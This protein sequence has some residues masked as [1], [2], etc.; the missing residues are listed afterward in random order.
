[1]IKI[2]DSSLNRQ[3]ILKEV[4]EPNRFEEI[5][6]ENT[7]TFSA[8]LDEKASTY[9]DE[10]SI[11]EIDGDYFDL[12]YYSKNQNEDGTLTIDV[13]AEHVSYRLNNYSLEYYTKIGTPTEILTE[14]LAGTG[15]SVGTVELTDSVTYSAL[16]EMTKRQLVMDFVKNIGGEID[17]EKFEVSILN[18]RGS[19]S[20]R[21]LTTGK[22]IRIISKV[23]NKRE[24][25][26]S[27][28][29]LVAYTCEP[30]QPT[31]YPFMLGDEVLLIQ[32]DLGIQETL[33]IVRLGY[34]PYNPMTAEIELAN[35]ISG[36][37][38]QMYRITTTTV[39][40][41][42]IYNGCRI[43]PD[44]GFVAERSDGKAKTVMNATEGISIYSDLGSG[45]AKNFFVGLDG[46]IQAKGL[47]ID[48]S[49][50]F[51]GTLSAADGTFSGTISASTITGSII[52]GSTVMGGTDTIIKL[53]NGDSGF[54]TLEF[55]AADYRQAAIWYESTYSI[56]HIE[57]EGRQINIDADYLN[58]NG[59]S[60]ATEQWVDNNYPTK[61]FVDDYYSP[62]THNHGD[63]YV[64]SHTGQDLSIT[65]TS[66]GIVIRVDGV[67]LGSILYD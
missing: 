46:R 60:I 44:E 53:H 45:L 30:I 20:P 47:D 32:K 42:K 2:L 54:G 36:V 9:I 19:E 27:G 4:I 18:H 5:N 65:A 13:E 25:D 67:T 55:L 58:F 14:L 35:F 38:D 17:F 7:L 48:G 37:E 31:G 24:T 22:N 64:K 49:G 52:T 61:W 15:F 10:D 66:S 11:L 34:D 63:A 62:R 29:P 26:E 28:N 41:E 16:E 33:R 12:V 43:G 57:A 3:A 59:Y 6:G 23:Y 50:T 21:I 8:V 1:M 56:F 51:S 40:K 39:A